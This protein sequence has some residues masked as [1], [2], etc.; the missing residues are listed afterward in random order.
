MRYKQE[1]IRCDGCNTILKE[2]SFYINNGS[3]Q[4]TIKKIND[5]DLCMS[6]FGKVADMYFREHKISADELEPFIEK[7]KPLSE[8]LFGGLNGESVSSGF[9]FSSLKI[10]ATDIANEAYKKAKSKFIDPIV[11]NND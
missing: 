6:C 9:T 5:K 10:N 4:E 2:P 3:H 11:K 7:I 8:R 1:T